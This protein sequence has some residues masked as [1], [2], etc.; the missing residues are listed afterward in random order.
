M[1]GGTLFCLLVKCNSWDSS[2]WI[3]EQLAT[4]NKTN[5]FFLVFHS[6]VLFFMGNLILE[7]CFH[8]EAKHVPNIFLKKFGG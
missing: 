8:I 6:F 2:M 3:V 1:V 5:Y 4:P 7:R